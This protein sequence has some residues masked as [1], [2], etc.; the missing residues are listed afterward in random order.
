M[1]IRLPFGFSPS[2]IYADA[3]TFAKKNGA[4]VL[5][6][7]WGYNSANPN[8]YPNIRSAIEDAT[9]TGRGGK[10]CI[11]AFAAGNTANHATGND[12]G[13]TFPSNVIVAGVL[14]VGASDRYDQQANYSPTSNLNSS[15]NQIIDILAPSHRAY[16]CQIATET[17][18]IWTIDIPG[19]AG[20]NPNRSRDCGSLPP[21]SDLPSSGTNYLAYTGYFG[22]TSASC[23]QV[24]GVAALILSL[25]PDLTQ[26]Q[27]SNIIKSTARKAG[28]YRYL[29]TPGIDGNGTWNPQMG[30]GVL[31]AYNALRA[32]QETLPYNVLGTLF[33][34]VHH[35]ESAISMLFNTTAE[36]YAVPETSVNDPLEVILRSAPLYKTTVVHYD[37]SIFVPGTPKNPGFSGNINNPGYPIDWSII[38]LEPSSPDITPIRPDE[39]PNRP[40]GVYCFRNV[41]SGDYILALS[42]PGYIPRFV[43]ITVPSEGKLLIDHREIIGGDMNDDRKID[44]T[45]VSEIGK[46]AGYDFGSRN[47]DTK[48]D[49]NGN[50][51]IEAGDISLVKFLRGFHIEGYTDTKEWLDEYK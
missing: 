4:H 10:G 46:K 26:Q 7:S 27:V 17:F 43:K 39:V 51:E 44:D 45:D 38:G 48:Y 21:N 19:A 18:E 20:Y 31:D 50:G 40:V 42:R 23:P 6:N 8:L 14:T 2:S 22:G 41:N 32:T 12:G 33:P 37:G 30:H 13:V 16:S 1:P 3:I 49:I 29:I 25:N 5:S 9:L 11:V 35:G 34:F 28:N 36:L 24:A 47:Y 15:Q